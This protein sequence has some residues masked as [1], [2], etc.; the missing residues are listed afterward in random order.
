MNQKYVGQSDYEIHITERTKVTILYDRW[1][2]WYITTIESPLWWHNRINKDFLLTFRL[3]FQLTLRLTFPLTFRLNFRLTYWI[4]TLR[5]FVSK[6]FIF[7]GKFFF[8]KIF[9][10]N[11]FFEIFFPKFLVNP[12]F[13]YLTFRYNF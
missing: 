12:N 8:R 5:N 10:R 3:T 6:I 7:F 2:E 11:F 13:E 1:C 9:F 4:F